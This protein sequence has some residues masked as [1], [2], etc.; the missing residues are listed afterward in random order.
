MPCIKWEEQTHTRKN[1]CTSRS[2][3]KLITAKTEVKQAVAKFT[4]SCGEKLRREKTCARKVHVFIQTN[5]HRPTDPQYFQSITL[6][7]PVASNLTSE[8]MKY[9]MRGLEMIFQPGYH[10]QKAGVM[11]LDL[12]PAS[13]IQL[14]LFDKENRGRD[15]KLMDS[16]DKVNKAFGKDRVRFGV[17][18]YGTS[19]KL[20]QGNLSP[21]YT[22]R[23]DQIPIVKAS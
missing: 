22:T 12:V 3:G 5:P 9:S 4:A 11:V 16:L 18:S 6:E 14:G 13:E 17:Q 1:I 8:L 21:C 23:L 15:Q 20:K 10:Y 7:L 19:W 2:F